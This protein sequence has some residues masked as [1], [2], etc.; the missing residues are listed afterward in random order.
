MCPSLPPFYGFFSK[1]PQFH[2]FDPTYGGGGLFPSPMPTCSFIILSAK[3]SFMKTYDKLIYC[4]IQKTNDGF[5]YYLYQ[6]FNQH[7]AI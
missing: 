4:H 5:M 1:F 2:T 7:K 6:I 3:L